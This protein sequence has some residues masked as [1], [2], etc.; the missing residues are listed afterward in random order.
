MSEIA[1]VEYKSANVTNPNEGLFA[2]LID[3]AT[4]I[5]TAALEQDKMALIG[6]PMVITRV[7]YRPKPAKMERGYVSIEAV[8][9]DVLH[10]EQAIR[11]GWMPGVERFDQFAFSP[12]ELIVFNDGGTGIRRQL[13]MLLQ[14]AGVLDIGTYDASLPV[15]GVHPAFDRD[16]SEW[17]TFKTYALQNSGATDADGNAIKIEVPDFGGLKIFARRGLRV[18]EYT[19]DGI[20]DA[21]T[22]YLS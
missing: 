12:E 14:S 20:G 21:T 6:V 7:T 17:E 3:G 16:W 22:F 19:A 1:E 11:R 8:I 5:Q 10:I 2:D 4:V 18:S 13:T 9:G 15:S